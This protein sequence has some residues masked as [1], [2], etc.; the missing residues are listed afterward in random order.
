[1]KTERCER[2][3]GRLHYVE[4][5]LGRLADQALGVICLAGG[6]LGSALIPGPGR[7]C[8]IMGAHAAK[9]QFA[10]TSRRQKILKCEKCRHKYK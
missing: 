10:N 9:I 5:T 2:C 1:M 6:V 4:D 3:G 7:T 8:V